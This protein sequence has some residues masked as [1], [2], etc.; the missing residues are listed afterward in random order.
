[1]NTTDE[2]FA[3]IF[4]V[5]GRSS[6][7]EL[8]DRETMAPPLGAGAL[9]LTEQLL[10]WPL[11]IALGV[12]S[13]P[14]STGKGG[15]PADVMLPSVPVMTPAVPFAKASAT[16]VSWTGIGPCTEEGRVTDNV[17][18]IPLEIVVEFCPARRQVVPLQESVFVT[19]GAASSVTAVAPGT[20]TVHPTPAVSPVPD[21]KETG[22]V[23]VVFATEA[24]PIVNEDDPAPKE[25]PA[26]QQASNKE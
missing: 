6:A 21:A 9:R 20:V 23:A 4:T 15:E 24:V 12:H 8:L 22:R 17:A 3:A 1:M 5:A 16:F 25:P 11:T 2:A 14:E 13:N 10:C 26:T 19:P 7:V 18:M